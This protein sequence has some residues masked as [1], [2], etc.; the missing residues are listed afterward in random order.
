VAVVR[1]HAKIILAEMVDGRCFAWES[2]ANM[3][4]CRNIES[5]VLTQDRD[6]LE[7]HRGWMQE[8]LSQGDSE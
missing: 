1:N 2:S 8:L 3:R 4:S 5:Y 6:L 7:F